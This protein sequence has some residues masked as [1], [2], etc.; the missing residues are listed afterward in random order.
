MK[1]KL[2]LICPLI[3]LLGCATVKTVRMLPG[4]MY[5][6]KDGTEMTFAAQFSYGTGILT[7]YNPVTSENFTGQYTGIYTDG[8]VT[9][10]EHTNSLGF[11]TGTYTTQT[12]ANHAKIKGILKG[13]KGTIITIEMDIQTG[14]NPKGIGEG[15]DNYGVHYQ[16]QL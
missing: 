7:A 11:S 5:S 12:A 8:G 13:D 9:Q 2:L 10:T 14:D 15:T 4:K 1:T 16:I 3:L 6:L